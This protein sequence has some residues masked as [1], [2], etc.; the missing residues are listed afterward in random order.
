MTSVNYAPDGVTQDVCQRVTYTR[1]RGAGMGNGGDALGK[2]TSK[3]WGQASGCMASVEDYA[4][5][6]SG[7]CSGAAR[8]DAE[9]FRAAAVSGER[10]PL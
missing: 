2:V 3:N 10:L 7:E 8:G 5:T 6:A 4:Y 1:F 9:Q